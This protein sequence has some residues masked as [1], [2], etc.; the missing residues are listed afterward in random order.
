[1][2]RTKEAEGS[3]QDTMVGWLLHKNRRIIEKTRPGMD[4]LLAILSTR[5]SYK[6]F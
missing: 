1:M 5:N 6:K 3:G 2:L 4:V